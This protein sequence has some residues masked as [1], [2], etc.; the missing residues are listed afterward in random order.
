MSASH[1]RPSPRR[2]RRPRGCAGPIRL[3]SS[4]TGLA[5]LELAAA[6]D[7]IGSGFGES[8]RHRAAEALARA[9]DDDDFSVRP[10]RRDAH[11]A[12]SDAISCGARQQQIRLRAEEFVDRLARLAAQEFGVAAFQRDRQLPAREDV[13]P[14]DRADVSRPEAMA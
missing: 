2:G 12:A 1:W 14:A 8:E 7:D 11:A 10:K 6:D 9:G 4:A 13:V 5:R 3:I